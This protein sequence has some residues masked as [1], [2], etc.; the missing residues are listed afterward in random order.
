MQT[1]WW[2]THPY[3]RRSVDA[4]VEEFAGWPTLLRLVEAAEKP[5][6]RAFLA[7][8]F[9]TGGRVSETLALRRDNFDVI[10]EEGVIVV[11][12]MP[13]LKRFRKLS[14]YTDE[15]GVTRWETETLEA[16]RRPF[17]ILM[18]EPLAP[19]VVEWVEASEGLLFPS[20]RRPGPLSRFWA[21]KLIKKI[22]EETGVP[23]WPHWFRSQ[24]ASQL[25]A[26]YGFEVIDLVDYFSWRKSD[27]ALT[28]AR[29]G[30]RGLASK[31][32]PVK[33]V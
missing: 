24:R 19:I 6:D 4:D 27:I 31:M 2:A 7:T 28:Y 29:R 10:T 33:Y 32:R 3:E 14:E 9:E 23:C 1:G 8:L 5:R 18:A 17:P 12:G 30:W 20:P 15:D 22:S 26:D 16:T 11:K 21:Y 25:V 13:L